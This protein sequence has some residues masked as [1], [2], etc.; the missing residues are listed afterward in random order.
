MLVYHGATGDAPSRRWRWLARTWCPAELTTRW[1]AGHLRQQ[2]KR[3]TDRLTYAAAC[4]STYRVSSSQHCCISLLL[5]NDDVALAWLRMDS[6]HRSR[7]CHWW[8]PKINYRP[9]FITPSTLNEIS[10]LFSWR[11]S[12]KSAKKWWLKI[13]PCTSQTLSLHVIGLLTVPSSSKSRSLQS[14][15]Y[16]LYKTLGVHLLNGL[17]DYDKIK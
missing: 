8:D 5:M 1:P 11:I 14:Q 10:K 12:R 6:I 17:T 2:G 4:T 15:M 16:N 3:Q 13:T 7:H 9:S